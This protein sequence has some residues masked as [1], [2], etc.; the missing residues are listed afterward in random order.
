MFTGITQVQKYYPNNKLLTDDVLI[1]LFEKH[2][3]NMT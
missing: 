1:Y 3:N 2:D